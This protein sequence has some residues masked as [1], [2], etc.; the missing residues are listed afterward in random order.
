SVTC[1]NRAD[2]GALSSSDRN[3]NGSERRASDRRLANEADRPGRSSPRPLRE[4]KPRILGTICRQITVGKQNRAFVHGEALRSITPGNSGR[5]RQGDQH[6]RTPTLE[7][8]RS[9]CAA[10][11]TSPLTPPARPGHWDP[12]ALPRLSWF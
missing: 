8:E 1:P 9:P 5:C 2:R 11:I 6:Q 12:P 3:A 7:K 10:K 4:A